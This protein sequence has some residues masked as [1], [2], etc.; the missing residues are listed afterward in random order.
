M[1]RGIVSTGPLHEALLV[2]SEE[3]RQAFLNRFKAIVSDD[4]GIILHFFGNRIPLTKGRTD[5]LLR[6]L[7]AAS[8]EKK[9]QRQDPDHKGDDDNTQKEA[10]SDGQKHGSE[11]A[12]VD[13]DVKDGTTD[14]TSGSKP[15]PPDGY[16]SD[17]RGNLQG[18][19]PL[20]PGCCHSSLFLDV[21]SIRHSPETAPLE[22][23]APQCQEVMDPKVRKQ[24]CEV[25]RE[26]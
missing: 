24:G 16:G 3:V 13:E 17:L 22:V 11:T 2:A 9:Q 5:Q 7:P 23:P 12:P 21:R 15:S 26:H 4:P 25:W 20:Y 6:L 14:S 18:D 1:R 19:R 8:V 10:D